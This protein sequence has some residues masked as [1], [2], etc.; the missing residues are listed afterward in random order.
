MKNSEEKTKSPYRVNTYHG[1]NICWMCQLSF[2]D[3]K[4]LAR[5]NK[6]AHERIDELWWHTMQGELRC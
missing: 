1:D 6:E 3:W 2:Y 4:D 5:H